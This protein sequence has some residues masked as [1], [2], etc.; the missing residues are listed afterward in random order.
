MATLFRS[1]AVCRLCL[2]LLWTGLVFLNSLNA[3]FKCDCVICV[4]SVASSLSFFVKRVI[5][6]SS[7]Q[8]CC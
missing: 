7:Q 1:H 2:R 6:T 8:Q 3:V 4:D 5:R